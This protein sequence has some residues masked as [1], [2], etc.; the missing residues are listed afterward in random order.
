MRLPRHNR[1][2]DLPLTEP[3]RVDFGSWA[4]PR[5]LAGTGEG[6]RPADHLVVSV[7]VGLCRRQLP[8]AVSGHQ[9]ADVI[10]LGVGQV[11]SATE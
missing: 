5:F 4:R 6:Q 10:N 1:E 3:A 8:D 11:D 7:A 9:L 2:V